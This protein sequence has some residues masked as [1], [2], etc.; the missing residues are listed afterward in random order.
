MIRYIL[1]ALT[2][3]ASFAVGSLLYLLATEEVDNFKGKF[4]SEKLSKAKGVALVPIGLLGLLFAMTTETQYFMIASLILL[5]IGIVFG[6][7]VIAEKEKRLLAKYTVETIITFLVFF[8]F[9]Y[10]FL[11]L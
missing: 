8:F 4:R 5:I 11:N 1:L 9:V 2:I 10:F 7:L 6:S 3:A